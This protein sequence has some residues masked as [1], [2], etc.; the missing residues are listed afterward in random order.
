MAATQ[1]VLNISELLNLILRQVPPRDLLTRAQRVCRQW[2][3]A[4]TNTPIPRQMLYLSASPI[5]SVGRRYDKNTIAAFVFPPLFNTR[6]L[7]A[8][9]DN[10]YV[11]TQPRIMAVGRLALKFRQGILWKWLRHDAS[12]RTMHMAQPPITKLHWEITRDDRLDQDLPE[13]LPDATAV[14]SFPD[15]LRIGQL[16][17][18]IVATKSTC[19]ITWPTVRAGPLPLTPPPMDSIEEWVKNRQDTADSA[20]A[21][22]VQQRVIDEETFFNDIPEDMDPEDEDHPSQ[23][24]LHTRLSFSFLCIRHKL[25][26]EELQTLQ[27]AEPGP[28][29]EPWTYVPVTQDR[30]RLFANLAQRP[31]IPPENFEDSEDSD[32]N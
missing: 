2:R 25:C 4:I 7:V 24:S 11:D 3:E 13:N 21:L 32:D 31:F 10:A 26:L 19:K 12:W 23:Y 14:F 1:K 20:L 15:G 17:D 29:V 22:T 18:L 30:E 9:G 27:R 5:C 16:F 8:Y 28:G 6:F